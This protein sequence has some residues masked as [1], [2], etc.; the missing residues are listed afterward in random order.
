MVVCCLLKDI[1][2]RTLMLQAYLVTE[3]QN[4]E[5][6]SKKEV[7][8]WLVTA[9]DDAI[10]GQRFDGYEFRAVDVMKVGFLSDSFL[11]YNF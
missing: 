1:V 3:E 7:F 4:R 6:L 11:A 5:L 2:L 10:R 8:E 9:L